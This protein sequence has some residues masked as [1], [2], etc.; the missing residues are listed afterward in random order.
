MCFD[1]ID[2]T[3]IAVAMPILSC[4]D[5]PTRITT[6]Y[7]KPIYATNSTTPPASVI[8]FS[9]SL[10]THLARTTIGML[11]RRP[12]PRTLEYPRGRRSMTGTVS[13][14]LDWRYSSRFSAGT[15]DQSCESI[16]HHSPPPRHGLK[17]FCRG[18]KYQGGMHTLS[19]LTTGF[20]K[21]FCCLWK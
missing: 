12:F 6:L 13:V 2:R 4:H 10:E 18:A 5:I 3:P 19:R 17:A 11:G 7:H 20:Q 8:F 9:A 14:F 1:I 21:W 15:S 16:S